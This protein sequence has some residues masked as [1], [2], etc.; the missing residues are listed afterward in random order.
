M[1]WRSELW[2][3]TKHMQIANRRER[4]STG[5]SPTTV[6][7]TRVARYVFPQ[8]MYFPHPHVCRPRCAAAFIHAD[9]SSC[10]RRSRLGRCSSSSPSHTLLLTLIESPPLALEV[11]AGEPGKS[12]QVSQASEVGGRVCRESSRLRALSRRS[13]SAERVP[14][15]RL[16]Q[17]GEAFAAMGAKELLVYIQKEGGARLQRA[18]MHA[19]RASAGRASI[20]RAAARCDMA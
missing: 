16:V 9:G 7:V 13:T 5:G 8:I 15:A 1:R 3:A 12:A 6:S 19:S 11:G 17:V 4:E 18:R 10:R 20:H 14:V 2:R